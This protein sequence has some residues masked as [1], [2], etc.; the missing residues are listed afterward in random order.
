MPW[1]ANDIPT[2]HSHPPVSYRWV[3]WAKSSPYC[4]QNLR[5]F[6]H[7]FRRSCIAEPVR[8]AGLYG[9][10]PYNRSIWRHRVAARA[11]DPLH[12]SPRRPEN[13]DHQHRGDHVDGGQDQP[14]LQVLAGSALLFGVHRQI[15]KLASEHYFAERA[16][17]GCVSKYTQFRSS[18][19]NSFD[20]ASVSF[21]VPHLERSEATK[22]FFA[23]ARNSVAGRIFA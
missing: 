10:D 15:P 16:I 2:L 6:H 12:A 3:R 18:A 11:V 21:A 5:L 7:N 22:N 19:S 23:R 8:S 1:A 17:R 4:K 9:V 13:P 14:C 20:I